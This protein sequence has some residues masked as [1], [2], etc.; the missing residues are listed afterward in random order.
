[1]DCAV[2]GVSHDTR[3]FYSNLDQTTRKADGL[4]RG[5]PGPPTAP[6]AAS[7]EKGGEARSCGG[8]ANGPGPGRRR[9]GPGPFAKES[10]FS[11]W[12]STGEAALVRTDSMPFIAPALVL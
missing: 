4:L 12:S 8:T 7:A 1:M 5:D 2:N 10:Q 9:P 6:A 11:V 3:T